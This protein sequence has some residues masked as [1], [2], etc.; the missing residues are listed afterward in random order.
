MSDLVLRPLL[1]HA[2]A[3]SATVWVET[4]GPAT[5]RV[6]EAE[7]HTFEVEGHHYALV[8]IDGLEPGTDRPYEV[9][10]DGR[11]VWPEDGDERPAPRIRTT[12]PDVPPDISFGSCRTVRPHRAPWTHPPEKD[13]QGV[14]IDALVALAVE[15]RTGRRPLPD[16]LLLL[17]DQVYADE[18]LSPTVQ[19]RVKPR[20]GDAEPA[21]EVADFEEYTWLYR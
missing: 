18:G 1:R 13:P 12:R 21:G 20:R 14:G 11:R 6:L 7:A 15:C 9:A 16:L 2:D 10:L 17:G 19:D 8:L 4:S 3:T 5:V